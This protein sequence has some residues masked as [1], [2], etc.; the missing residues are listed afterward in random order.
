MRDST[1]I[2]H[3]Q[4]EKLGLMLGLVPSREVANSVLSLRLDDAYQPVVDLMWS[5]QLSAIQSQVLQE[6]TGAPAH[7]LNHLPLVGIE[8]ENTTPT[9]KTME[10]DLANIAALGTRLGLLV[11]SEQGES[12]IYRRAVRAVRTFRRAFG[13]M[14]TVPMDASW[15]TELLE[16]KWTSDLSVLPPT[17]K[18][19]PRGGERTPWTIKSRAFLRN[20]GEKAGFVVMEPYKPQ[21]IPIAFQHAQNQRPESMRHTHNPILGT[22]EMLRNPGDF[23]TSCEIDMAWLL[24]L[25]LGL[26]E[27]LAAISKRDPCLRD[28]GLIWPELYNHIPV[29][30][31]EFETASGK[32][33][34]GGL[35]N[36]GAYSVIGIAVAGSGAVRNELRKT[37]RRYQPTLG[38]RNVHVMEQ[39]APE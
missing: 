28:H 4:L 7:R 24:P 6:V 2:V 15:L 29:V 13:D 37:L 34:G 33:A 22:K 30:A 1:K 36:L 23:L 19:L 9:T 3:H 39:I 18:G 11:V 20:L 21:V 17:S 25:P 32:H 26:Q 38:L 12:G 16:S 35:L 8:V 27:M 31:F 5:L 10:S 14:N